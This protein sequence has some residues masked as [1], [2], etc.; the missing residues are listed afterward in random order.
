MCFGYEPE[1]DPTG[2]NLLIFSIAGVILLIVLG[3]AF[4]NAY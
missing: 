2:I 3:F 4:A 1:N